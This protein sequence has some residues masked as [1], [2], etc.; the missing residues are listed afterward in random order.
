MLLLPGNIFRFRKC[1][2]L[3][4]KDIKEAASFKPAGFFLQ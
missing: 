3:K 2:S 1:E 4:N